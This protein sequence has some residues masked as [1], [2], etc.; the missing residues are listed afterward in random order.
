MNIS[1]IAVLTKPE[2]FK[3]VE[4]VLGSDSDFEVFF[5]DEVG[6]FV[7]V[8]EGSIDDEIRKLTK[9]QNIEG[10]ISAD[11]VYSYDENELDEA[12][13]K[14]D[15]NIATDMLNDENLKAENIKYFGDLKKR[16]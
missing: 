2:S 11:M 12:K 14:F 7:V 16:F 4:R 15:L 3:V 8:I 6:K 5:K 9:L 1:S 13:G 10:V